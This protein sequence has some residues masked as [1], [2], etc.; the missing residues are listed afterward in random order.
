MSEIQVW[1]NSN[2]L[3][4]SPAKIEF[5]VFGEVAVRKRLE[6]ILQ[7]HRLGVGFEAAEAVRNL[8]VIF[9]CDFSFKK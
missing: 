7:T 8:D 3:K 4:L 9:D 5:M 2:K 1:M 6:P